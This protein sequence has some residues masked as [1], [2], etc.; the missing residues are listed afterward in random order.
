[1]SR[2]Y[3]AI[4]DQTDKQKISKSPLFGY[5]K[6][7]NDDDGKLICNRIIPYRISLITE[8]RCFKCDGVWYN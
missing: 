2:F 4:N 5:R 6:P 3:D 7:E 8:I 1:M